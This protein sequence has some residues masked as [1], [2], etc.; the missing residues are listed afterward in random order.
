MERTFLEE[1]NLK[2]GSKPPEWVF[3]LASKHQQ[4]MLEDI[5]REIGMRR[6]NIAQLKFEIERE[7]YL[8]DWL[9]ET[10]TKLQDKDR[11]STTSTEASS[12][13]VQEN[14]QEIQ[15]NGVCYSPDEN[16][17]VFEDSLKKDS[18]QKDK[19]NDPID[20][21]EDSDQ[22]DKLNDPIDSSEGVEN[23]PEY[24]SPSVEEST[25]KT[26]PLS[27]QDSPYCLQSVSKESFRSTTDSS[28][29]Y[30][31]G[32]ISSLETSIPDD[33]TS[34]ESASP[35]F[36]R[37]RI[38]HKVLGGDVQIAK[39]VRRRLIEQGRHWSCQY[40]DLEG[41]NDS[42]L[43]PQKSSPVL[44]RR[45]VS[46]PVSSVSQSVP[47]SIPSETTRRRVLSSVLPSLPLSSP[48]PPKHTE[49][50]EPLNSLQPVVLE[51]EEAEQKDKETESPSKDDT[52]Q[53]MITDDDVKGSI[54]HDGGSL[55]IVGKRGSNGIVLDALETNK[56]LAIE[57]DEECDP[58]LLNIMAS[59]AQN[60]RTP[61]SSLDQTRDRIR[62]VRL[63]NGDLEAYCSGSPKNRYSADGKE[64]ILADPTSDG[65]PVYLR[66]RGSTELSPLYPVSKYDRRSVTIE[67]DDC[68][69][70]KGELAMS[71]TP[72]SID[73]MNNTNESSGSISDELI[74]SHSDPTS[75]ITR[76]RAFLISQRQ[77][78]GR[79]D[80]LTDERGAGMSRDLDILEPF[81]EKEV[82]PTLTLTRNR[83]LGNIES[84]P[85]NKQSSSAGFL[86]LDSLSEDLQKALSQIRTTPEMSMATLLDLEENT[87]MNEQLRES[88]SEPSLDDLELFESGEVD[89]ATISAYTLRNEIYG[90]NSTTSIP[91]LFMGSE[92]VSSTC[93]SPP[94]IPNSPTHSLVNLRPSSGGKRRGRER[95][96]NAELDSI[97]TVGSDDGSD[98]SPSH[99]PRSSTSP[100][101]DESSDI[102]SPVNL[103][104][105]GRI[106]TTT[107]APPEVSG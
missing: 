24:L 80:T 86:R 61:R 47:L 68:M 72:D 48:I 67:D 21:S 96:G 97:T 82:D 89:E 14:S 70:P 79:Q 65:E 30:T 56:I 94:D 74:S 53:A 85:D 93:S 91:S 77:N 101:A 33:N 71:L 100:L 23:S 55:P 9:C 2:F 26:S 95:M 36:S 17:V 102:F 44:I 64:N 11:P 81:D 76:D 19:L 8:L 3:H 105:H 99:V 29:Y 25:E 50:S 51:S 69:T 66:K 49:D 6:A 90:N 35:L 32:Q 60:S 57:D 78:V 46:D 31:A 28:E 83:A 106:F 98:L 15:V 39:A 45:S 7:E 107:E 12:L 27:R 54:L 18:D 59:R 84:T 13:I 41:I 52:A 73:T 92:S 43:L 34:G 42:P 4:H 22:K 58:S 40:L 20:S 62:A 5:D 104:P 1:W 87:E 75:A 63:S 103:R 38:T 88:Y 10:K 16:H 37:E